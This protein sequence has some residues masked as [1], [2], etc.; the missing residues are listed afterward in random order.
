LIFDERR[1]GLIDLV[2]LPKARQRDGA[3]FDGSTRLDPFEVVVFVFRTDVEG[4]PIG[5]FQRSGSV[6]L[7]HTAADAVLHS[8]LLTRGDSDA[9]VVIRDDGKRKGTQITLG[10]GTLEP[11]P[12]LAPDD[13]EA[14]ES[15][16]GD[17]RYTLVQKLAHVASRGFNIRPREIRWKANGS[18]T[19]APELRYAPSR[20][21]SDEHEIY[22]RGLRRILSMTGVPLALI[23]L[24]EEVN[25]RGTLVVQLVDFLR[26]LETDRELILPVVMQVLVRAVLVAGLEVRPGD[27]E[28]SFDRIS[29]FTAII[30]QEVEGQLASAFEALVRTE[31]V[32]PI[33]ALQRTYGLSDEE[34]RRV[35]QDGPGGVVERA[36][37]V[38][39]RASLS[40]GAEVEVEA[41]RLES[42]LA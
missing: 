26:L 36:R 2:P 10:P 33:W 12:D 19:T 5:I 16:V 38:P 25:A 17:T 29:T 30:G 35:I 4:R 3:W 14:L 22:W 32:D 1:W 18:G 28:L 7:R 24:E 37:S 21:L 6:V 20:R 15:G 42:F 41:L 40:L 39:E 31:R 8:L 11:D 13:E 9:T 34:A 23:G 27:L